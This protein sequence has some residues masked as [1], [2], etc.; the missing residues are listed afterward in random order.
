MIN[1]ERR[2]TASPYWKTDMKIK[3]TIKSWNDDKG[4][5]FVESN[6]GERAF[7]HIKAFTAR[8]RRPVNGDLIIYDLLRDHNNRYQADKIKFYSVHKK[9]KS[10]S[11]VGTLFILIFCVLLAATVLTGKLPVA[12]AVIYIFMSFIAFIA[13]AM[14]KSAA[15]KGRWRTQERTLHLFSLLG[16]W[17]GAWFAQNRL[18][19]KSNKTEFKAFYRVTVIVNI[20]AF[21]YLLSASGIRFMSNIILFVAR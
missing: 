3:G 15:R 21:F 4:F 18:R 6:T 19:H 14:D 16:G 8:S 17:P 20:S 13:Y 7:V 9:S 1:F 5:G 2:L 12:V 11:V 10:S